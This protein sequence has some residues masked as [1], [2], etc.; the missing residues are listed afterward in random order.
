[1]GREPLRQPLVSVSYEPTFESK[2]DPN[3]PRCQRRRTELD[4]NSVGYIGRIRNETGG[5][6]DH[7][8][9]FSPRGIAGCSLYIPDSAL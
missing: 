8:H 1:M 3:Q 5:R 7:D 4:G 9:V 6:S 2:I